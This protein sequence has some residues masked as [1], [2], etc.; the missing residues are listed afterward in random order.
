MDNVNGNGAKP[1]GEISEKSKNVYLKFLTTWQNKGWIKP[2]VSKSPDGKYARFL[3]SYS[4][5]SNHKALYDS[6]LS[7]YTKP[8][9]VKTHLSAMTH[10]LKVSKA[11]QK[12][13]DYYSDESSKH[14]KVSKA[15]AD[16]NV[17]SLNKYTLDDIKKILRDMI[18]K[19]D[20]NKP[21]SPNTINKL[22]LLTL[23]TQRPPPRTEYSEMVLTDKTRIGGQTNY[24]NTKTKRFTF[25]RFK[26][27]KRGSNITAPL[28]KETSAFIEETL[29]MFPRKYLLSNPKDGNEPLGYQAMNYLLNS[30]LGKGYGMN[31]IRSIYVSDFLSKT[32]SNEEK[33]KLAEQMMTSAETFDRYYKNRNIMWLEDEDKFETETDSPDTNEEE[34]EEDQIAVPENKGKVRSNR[35]APPVTKTVQPKV[36]VAPSL[37]TDCGVKTRQTRTK[38]DKP[39]RQDDNYNSSYYEKNK[40]KLSVKASK[41][42]QDPET[43]KKDDRKHVLNR[44]VKHQMD[45]SKY[46]SVKASTLRTH[47]VSQED[48]DKR[49]AERTSN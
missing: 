49:V 20:P 47:C 12:I 11:S 1:L 9:V 19:I 24:Y 39:S 42:Y 4:V 40:E 2:A 38:L 28:D 26:T 34:D 5:K 25:S 10:H 8:N 16:K 30:M 33:L 6:I 21:L 13:I 48:I 36:D 15:E 46:P 27:D 18:D 7:E 31:Q 43:K 14:D 37:P 22:L 41:R 17:R 29:R 32:H 23:L 35:T 45:P 3:S 44:A